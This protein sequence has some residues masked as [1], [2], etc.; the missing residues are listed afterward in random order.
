MLKNEKSVIWQ[1][2]GLKILDDFSKSRALI[3]KYID[4]YID[5]CKC[6][7]I[8]SPLVCTLLSTKKYFISDKVP[9]NPEG[10]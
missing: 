6:V 4:P 9:L 7:V 10:T 1:K 3:E 8:A 5:H 2:Y